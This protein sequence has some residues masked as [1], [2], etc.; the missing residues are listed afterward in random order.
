MCPL[1]DLFAPAID[2]PLLFRVNFQHQIC[3][4]IKKRENGFYT[5]SGQL[6]PR[7]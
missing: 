5:P 3:F 1:G 2:T 4:V 7:A 6:V